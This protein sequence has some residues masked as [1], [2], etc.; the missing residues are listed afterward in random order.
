MAIRKETWEQALHSQ[1][2]CNLSGLAHWLVRLLDELRTNGI[3]S[4]DDL[5]QHPLVRLVVAQM[6][7]LAY[8]SFDCNTGN[9]WRRAYRLAEIETGGHPYYDRALEPGEKERILRQWAEEDRWATNEK[10]PTT[11]RQGRE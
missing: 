1:S 11:G 2:A 8:G 6:A 10:Q 5:S 4:T 7:H 3:N 9:L